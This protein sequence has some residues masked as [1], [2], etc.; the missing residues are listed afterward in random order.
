M[1]YRFLDLGLFVAL[2]VV[3]GGIMW[4]LF[5]LGSPARLANEQVERQMVMP[6]VTASVDAPAVVAAPTPIP[7]LPIEATSPAPVVTVPAATPPADGA[8]APPA[9]AATPAAAPAAT[10]AA[11]PAAAPTPPR[12]LAA[13]EVALERV[14]FSF[15]TGGPGACGVVLEPWI[16]VAVSR[17]LLAA[18]GCGASVRITLDDPAGNRREA[19]ATIADTMNPSFSRTVNVYV[20][21]DEPAF[22]YGLTTGTFAVR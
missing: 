9:A 13:G 10:P 21:R 22:A 6:E 7:G 14:G 1:R 12:P 5:S 19:I 8:V 11:A 18:H 2:V 20:G 15:V 17:D 16:H 3:A 4:T